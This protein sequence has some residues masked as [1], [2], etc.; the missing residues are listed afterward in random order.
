[1]RL[2]KS[3]AQKLR[4]QITEYARNHK[5]AAYGA[6]AERFG[7]NKSFVYAVCRDTNLLRP[8]YNILWHD[9]QS[10]RVQ[11]LLA[12]ADAGN[13]LAT[14][15][16]HFSLTRERIRKI[17]E[18][19]GRTTSLPSGYITVRSVANRLRVSP[20]TVSKIIPNEIRLRGQLRLMPAASEAYVADKLKQ[21]V[22][23]R[24]CHQQF[25]SLHRH[26]VFCCCKCRAAAS[27]AKKRRPYTSTTKHKIWIRK[28]YEL[29]LT[30]CTDY[31]NWITLRQAMTI[32][33]LTPMRVKYL[34]FK[35]LIRTK[36]DG[37][38]RRGRT[39]YLLLSEHDMLIAGQLYD[40][41][42]DKW[43]NNKSPAS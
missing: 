24:Y 22:S 6:M 2:K 31:T 34:Q 16:K 26:Q 42:G 25:T 18:L 12:M 8:N 4:E 19:Y 9:P 36:P 41:H 17:L 39:P 37:N 11:E 21:P 15:G 5:L 13:T 14:I 23:C 43:S 30:E 10:A 33:G 20:S 38:K 28:L 40:K 35:R 32:T 7:V 29:R 27:E 1:M 3:E